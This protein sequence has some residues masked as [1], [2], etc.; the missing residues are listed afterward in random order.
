LHSWKGVAFLHDCCNLPWILH[1]DIG[2]Q[3]LRF[4][5]EWTLGNYPI[6]SMYLYSW[7]KWMYYY[8]L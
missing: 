3:I 4:L 7:Y 6:P 5:V 2:R 1:S 8:L